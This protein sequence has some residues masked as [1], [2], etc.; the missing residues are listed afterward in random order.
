M[1]ESISDLINGI[2]DI[3]ANSLFA[4]LRV[5]FGW[6]AARERPT[7]LGVIS[8]TITALIAIMLISVLLAFLSAYLYIL[9]IVAAIGAIVALLGLS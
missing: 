5:L 6:D 8:K 7:W 4:I 1:L 3:V 2:V 9:A